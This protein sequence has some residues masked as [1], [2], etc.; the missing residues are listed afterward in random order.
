MWAGIAQ[1][2]SRTAEIAYLLSIGA[3]T[4]IPFFKIFSH[5]RNFGQNGNI[6]IVKYVILII[7]KFEQVQRKQWESLSKGL[8][9]CFEYK[10]WQMF[11]DSKFIGF[12]LLVFQVS[13]CLRLEA[14]KFLVLIV[15]RFAKLLPKWQHL[16]C[17][18]CHSN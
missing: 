2:V 15:F 13:W 14:K 4:K 3:T 11:V 8:R 17:K 10:P 16:D 12:D 6:L 5:Y 1:I 18:V 9:I 7:S